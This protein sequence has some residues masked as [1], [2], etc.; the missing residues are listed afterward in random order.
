VLG[1]AGWRGANCAADGIWLSRGD[2]RE[3]RWVTLDEA[4]ALEARAGDILEI[5]F[6]REWV[7][8]SGSVERPGYYPYLPGQTIADYVNLAGGPNEFG[9]DGGWKV[10]APTGE[11]LGLDVDKPVVAGARIWVPERR[12]HKFA[13]VLT[14]LGTA[15]AVVVSLTALLSK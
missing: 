1:A 5:P 11:R 14:P 8:V 10:Y 12:W 7:S 9:R 3:R 13:T 6:S 15:V 4:R 2:D